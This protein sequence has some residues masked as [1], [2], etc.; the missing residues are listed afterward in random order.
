M[1][2][3]L[4][5]KVFQPGQSEVIAK[6]APVQT[7]SSQEQNQ[8]EGSSQTSPSFAPPPPQPAFFQEDKPSESDRNAGAPKFNAI[9]IIKILIGLFAVLALLFV[10]FALVLP[11][12]TKKEEKVELTFWDISDNS[13]ISSI[14]PDFE[15]KYP[16]IK[17][18]YQKQDIKDYKER[19][20]T[21]SKNSTGPDV[22][23]FHNT[24]VL[25]LSDILLPIPSDVMTKE[26]F[27]KSF[28][29]VAKH[30]LSKNGAIYG[31]PLE[32]DTLALYVNSGLLR[33]NSVSI[34]TNWNDF[35]TA[36]RSL[37]LKDEKGKIKIAGAAMGVFDN[38]THA[39]DIISLL[40]VQDGVNLD[41]I[42]ADK[43][44]VADALR[45][46]TA[47]GQ[48]DG[49]VWDS[50]LETSI[51][52]FSKGNLAMYFGYLKDQTTIK[53]ANPTLSFETLSVPHLAGQ[54]MTIASYYPMGVSLKSKHQKE[55]SLLLRFLSDK[56]VVEKLTNLPLARTDLPDRSKGEVKGAVS[57]YFS[58]ETFDNGLNSKMNSQ[59]QSAINSI[60]SG[61]S[62]DTATDALSLGFS[63]VLNQFLPKP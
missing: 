44:R 49:S 58:G 46:Y 37:T 62:I 40:F 41:D 19:L 14:L 50:T 5:G 54:N 42:S 18:N 21:R 30:D 61:V 22:F 45:F 53:S 15:K 32:I 52:A 8:N 63:Q 10:I 51:T 26:E 56:D 35:I 2:D 4:R 33:Q 28:Y 34:P 13:N 11:N 57:T 12:L 27:S 31:I 39:P 17:V 20:V 3:P 38:V 7:E 9:N 60:F 25:Q 36:S 59:L 47:F 6:D 23:R 24:W 55:A 16:K 1:D 48:G 43:I 29:P